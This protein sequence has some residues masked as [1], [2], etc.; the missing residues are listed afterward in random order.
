MTLENY[1]LRDPRRLIEDVVAQH[2][3]REGRAYVVLVED[4]PG[5]QTI[6]AVRELSTPA[7]IED[8]HEAS[9]EIRDV[10]GRLGIPDSRRPIQHMLVTVLVRPG[11]CVF[12]PNEGRWMSAW[13]YSHHFADAFDSEVI[14]VTEHGWA[15]FMTDF[16]GHSPAIVA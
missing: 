12:G 6:K 13:R 16:A 4:P 1:E 10:V 11:L 15:D 8:Y 5:K 2:S 7:L 9:D 3:L 14:V